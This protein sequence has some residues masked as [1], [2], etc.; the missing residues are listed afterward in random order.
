[1]HSIILNIDRLSEELIFP[2]GTNPALSN[3]EQGSRADPHCL[4][5]HALHLVQGSIFLNA[6]LPYYGELACEVQGMEHAEAI[7]PELAVLPQ[8]DSDLLNPN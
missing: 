8:T 1:M 2:W 6:A 5:T 7:S 4:L 3:W